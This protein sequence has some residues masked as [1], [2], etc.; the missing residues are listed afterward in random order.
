MVK[1]RERKRD[2][3]SQHKNNKFLQKVFT[4]GNA[5]KANISETMRPSRPCAPV[6]SYW[7]NHHDHDHEQNWVAWNKQT[8]STT[9]TTTSPCGRTGSRRT[10]STTTTRRPRPR[11]RPQMELGCLQQTNFFQNHDHN[12]GLFLSSYEMGSKSTLELPWPQKKIK[13]VLKMKH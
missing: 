12:H 13:S 6:W 4:K 10:G 11:P 3:L 7:L 5:K 8:G 1:E 2:S 9:T